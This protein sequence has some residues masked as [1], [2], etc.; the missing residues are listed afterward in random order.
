MLEAMACGT[1]VLATPVGGIPEVIQHQVTGFVLPLGD[2]AS[3]EHGIQDAL[4]CPDL[5]VVA[6][7]SRALVVGGYSLSAVQAK[8]C[9][10][11]DELTVPCAVPEHRLS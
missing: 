7:R 8:W 2:P 1:P 4:E 3:I 10:I 11:L 5:R 6:Q 9:D